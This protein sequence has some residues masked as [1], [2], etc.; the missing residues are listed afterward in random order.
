MENCI[1]N[2]QSCHTVC[3]TTLNYCIK[4]GGKHA[5]PEHLKLLQDCVQICSTSADFMIRGSLHHSLTCGACSQLCEKCATSCE[6]VDAGDAQMKAC[7][8]ACRNCAASCKQMAGS[9][10]HH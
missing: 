3:L 7:I 8:E 2:C 1:K 9:H 5:E 10:H 4:K 6:A